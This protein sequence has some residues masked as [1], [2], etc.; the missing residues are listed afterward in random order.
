MQLFD[1]LFDILNRK[2][3]DFCKG[4]EDDEFGADL[5]GLPGE[6]E[7][8]L[9][10]MPAMEKQLFEAKK[11][12]EK[13]K[14]IVKISAKL[15]KENKELNLFNSKLLYTNKIFK[16]KTLKE[17]QKVK[18]LKAF[19]KAST[20]KEAKMIY[21]TLNTGITENPIHRRNMNFASKATPNVLRNRK[22]LTEEIVKSPMVAYFDKIAFNLD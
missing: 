4:L 15:L 11:E 6:E 17:N 16:T 13:L 10:G 19:D 18:V 22:P 3:S 14:G 7:E 1:Q 5:G 20:V 21:E 9:V 12:I 2:N 8:E